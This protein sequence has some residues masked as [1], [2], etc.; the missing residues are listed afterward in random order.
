MHNLGILHRD[1][2]LENIMM[3][4]NEEEAVPKLAD[5]GLSK[6]IGPGEMSTDSY[7]TVGY[8]SPE[9][10]KK[11]PYSYSCDIWSMGCIFHAMLSGYLPFDHSDNKEAVRM[12]L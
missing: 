4:S 3:S 6:I 1:L 12:T 2:K 7:G 10:L 11:E 8:C 5:F 9:V